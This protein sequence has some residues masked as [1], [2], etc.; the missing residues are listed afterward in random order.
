MSIDPSIIAAICAIPRLSRESNKSRIELVADSGYP[1]IRS[2]L[3][4][5]DLR[6]YLNDNPG[7]VNDWEGWSEDKRTSEGWYL[8]SSG[9]G[10]TVGY[11]GR[12]DSQVYYQSRVEACAQF[13]VYELGEIASHDGPLRAPPNTR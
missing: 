5:A 8:S 12:A 10:A 1:T 13:I 11:V 2:S 9:Q 4:A 6:V 7:I 3:T